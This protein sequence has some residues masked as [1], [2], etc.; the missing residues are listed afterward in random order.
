MLEHWMPLTKNRFSRADFDFVAA[1]LSDE[2]SR[3][4]LTKLWGDPDG[5]REILDL[6]EVFRCLIG[7]PSALAVSP[8]FYFYVLV[9]HSFLDADLSDV[10]LADYVAGVLA[11][12]VALTGGD[13]LEDVTRGFTHAA[14]FLSFISRSKG[15]MRFHL[16]VAA[17]DQFLVL[18][19]LYPQ[20]LNRRSERGEAPDLGFYET[21]ASHAYRSAAECRLASTDTGRR[22]FGT[23][24]ESLPSA[25]RSLN[26]VAEEFV[27]LG[28]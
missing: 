14:Q 4:H 11:R 6:K 13:P 10:A 20:F 8:R 19:G 25:R 26:R 23:L 18:T 3:R 7:S 12:R 28:E 22:V 9:R 27:F 21:F 5:R 24:A 2:S 15:R 1:A 17:G 16:Q